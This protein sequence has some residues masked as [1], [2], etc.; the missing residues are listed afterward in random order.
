[1][2]QAAIKTIH[3]ITSSTTIAEAI[4]QHPEIADTLMEA[5]VGCAGCG[6]SYMETIEE[7]LKGHGMTGEEV[8]A[9]V[10]KLNDAIKNND[11][12]KNNSEKDGQPLIV[13]E[14]AAEKLKQIIKEQK[15]EDHGLRVVVMPGGCSGFMYGF[16]FEKE[17]QEG[18]TILE[19]KGA[20]FFVDK[21]SLEMLHGSTV[22]Y[23]ES[24][25]GAGFKITNPNAT[26]TCGCGKS[27]R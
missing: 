10:K 25:Q 24:L 22:D 20:K 15:K 17:K 13:T 3:A 26:K 11:S 9:V 2:P 14:K 1:M 23:I 5:G 12:R 7:G 27:F 6:A 4:E 18:D 8:N 21:Q 16:E 19:V